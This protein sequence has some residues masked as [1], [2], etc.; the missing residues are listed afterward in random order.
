MALSRSNLKGVGFALAA[1][2]IFSTHDV[3]IKSLGTTYAPFQILFFSALMG[4]PLATMMMMSDKEPG[5]LRPVHPGWIAART[6][7]AILTGISAFYAFSVLPLATVYAFIFAA[8]LL[9][10]VLS[11]PILGERVGLHRWAA[12]FGLAF[13][14]LGSGLWSG[15]SWA[16]R[17]SMALYGIHASAAL[18]LLVRALIVTDE[19]AGVSWLA[20]A[21]LPAYAVAAA[22]LRKPRVRAFLSRS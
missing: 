8:P 13:I 15:R 21:I 10:T 17:G 6:V 14:V 18:A 22:F 2:A 12:L 5:T 20:L 4:F 7:S 3:V 16:R 19:L 1:Y 9:I 11:I